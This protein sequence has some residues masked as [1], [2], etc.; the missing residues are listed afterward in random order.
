MKP[1]NGAAIAEPIAVPALKMPTASAR[2]RIGNH[3]ATPLTPAGKFAGSVAPSKNRK[4]VKCAAVRASP[5]SMFAID[6]PVTKIKN[7]R[8]VP[9]QSTSRPLTAYMRV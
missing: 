6:Q 5:C 7:E 9:S 8:R 2:S 3:S 4:I 1:T